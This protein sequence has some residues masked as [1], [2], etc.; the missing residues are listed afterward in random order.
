MVRR[1]YDRARA[2]QPVSLVSVDDGGQVGIRITQSARGCG[3]TEA[4]G[5]CGVIWV[6]VPEDQERR[7]E[8]RHNVVG[9]DAREV[10]SP[11]ARWHCVA[12]GQR[13]EAAAQRIHDASHGRQSVADHQIA[14]LD[15]A[16]MLQ[17]RTAG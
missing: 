3:R 12:I 1:H 11:G 2:A 7:V 17:P 16:R 14:A 9:N 10:R 13:S 6:G 8:L 15:R 5:V 4:A